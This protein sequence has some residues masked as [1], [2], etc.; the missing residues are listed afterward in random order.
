MFASL[1][2]ICKVKAALESEESMHRKTAGRLKDGVQPVVRSTIN[3]VSPTNWNISVGLLV[4]CFPVPK[5]QKCKKDKD[6]TK[7]PSQWLQLQK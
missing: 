4:Q 1:W 5:K 3:C 7:R 2:C 6:F